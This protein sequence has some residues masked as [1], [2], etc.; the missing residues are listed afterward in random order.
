[1]PVMSAVLILGGLVLLALGGEVLVR[2]AGGMARSL[3]MSPLLVGLTVV[4][5][6]TSAPELAVSLQSAAAG[7]PGL[8]VGNVVGSNIANVLLVLGLSAVIAP[9]TVAST[10]IRRDVPVL[11]GISALALVLRWT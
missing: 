11:I 7:T 8:A 1:M 4:A 10:V 9:L 5:F 3:G 2:G 6:A